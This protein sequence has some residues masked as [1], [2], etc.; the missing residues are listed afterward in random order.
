MYIFGFVIFLTYM[1][2][3]FWNIFNNSKQNQERN[4]EDRKKTSRV[5]DIDLDGMGDHTRF[6]YKKDN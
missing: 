5:D 1:Y 6:T 3:T 2:F 4:R